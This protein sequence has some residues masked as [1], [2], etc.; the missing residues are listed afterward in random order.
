[1]KYYFTVSILNKS[2]FPFLFIVNIAYQKP[3]YQQYPYVIGN[4]TFDASNAVDGLKSNMAWDG[5]QC[6]VSAEKKETAIWWVNLTRIHSIHHITIYFMTNNMAWGAVFFNLYLLLFKLFFNITQFTWYTLSDF[7]NDTFLSKFWYFE[8]PE[9]EF[10]FGFFCMIDHNATILEINKVT[11]LFIYIN[12]ITWNYRYFCFYIFKYYLT[13]INII[14]V[15]RYRYH[16]IIH[17]Y[18]LWMGLLSSTFQNIVLASIAHI[19]TMG[20]KK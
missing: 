7:T 16:I 2:C 15:R 13:L 9:E 11:N 10:F 12:A 4:D 6:A 20:R 14:T 17:L 3:A 18:K 8:K 1:M 19:L 5:G